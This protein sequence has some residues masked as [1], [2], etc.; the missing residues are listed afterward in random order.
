[1][2]QRA[3]PK[4]FTLC[5][6]KK[7]HNFNRKNIHNIPFHCHFKM[8][9]MV[10]VYPVHEAALHKCI[11]VLEY[12][13]SNA[14]EHSMSLLKQL[15]VETKNDCGQ[16]VAE[17][18]ARQYQTFQETLLKLNIGD[19]VHNAV[20]DIWPLYLNYSKSLLHYIASGGKWYGY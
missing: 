11:V 8:N 7:S 16:T 17:I 1:M 18:I 4:I 5:S 10:D 3:P 2:R 20:S 19:V 13:L 14:R 9:S 12:I 15:V 6:Q